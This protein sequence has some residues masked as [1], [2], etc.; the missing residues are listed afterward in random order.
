MTI[1][2]IIVTY[3]RKEELLRCINAVKN[4]TVKCTSILIVNNDSTD[5]TKE[6]LSSVAGI[7]LL[8]LEQNLGGSGGFHTGLKYAHEILKSDFYWLMD[9]DGY[10]S[11]NCLEQLLSKSSEYDYIMPA[12]I[13]INNHK[14]LSWAV[15]KRNK[16][17][18]ES[19]QEL[20][21]S[22]GQIMDYVTPF[23]GILLSKK[24]VDEVG[25][26]NPDFF[27]WGDEY[28]HYWRCI[29][30]GIKPVTF[31]DAIFYHPSQ[32]LPLVPICFGL[33]R[34]PYVDSEL[35]MIC[36]VRNYTY[37]YRHYKQWYKIPVK[38]VMYW[39]LFNITRRFDRHGWKLYKESV[40]DGFKEDFSRHLK[41][42]K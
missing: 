26:I 39:W 34:V 24:C 36:L 4:Q 12:S 18:T 19:Y 21:E 22:W 17:K 16:I 42:L 3:N 32:K 41:Y 31:L 2:S 5:G 14:K 25:Y 29:Q 23:N 10:P 8:N 37:I 11:E 30:K 6:T 35:R 1:T 13:D 20:K 7:T 38:W 33:F 9:D 15:R 27:L 28:E 40:K